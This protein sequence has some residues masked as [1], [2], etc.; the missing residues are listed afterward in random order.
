MRDNRHYGKP[1]WR[2]GIRARQSAG[3]AR[4][5]AVLTERV[6]SVGADAEGKRRWSG[7]TLV[8]DGSVGTP[9]T[10]AK[11]RGVSGGVHPIPCR[12]RG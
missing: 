7:W 2:R 6:F 1:G 5:A 9:V 11:E 3:S 4:K 10:D 8:A 12:E